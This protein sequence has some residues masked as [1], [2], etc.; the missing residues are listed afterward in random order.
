MRSK[1]L[2]LA[3][4]G[5][6]GTIAAVGASKL[7]QGQGSAEKQPMA[8]IFVTVQDVEIGEQ[9]TAENIKL[10]PWPLDRMPEGA[11]KDLENVE[12]M[13]SNQRLY[14]GEPLIARKIS[15]TPGNT[16]RDIPRDYS[17][18]SLQTDT[19]TGMGT[20]VEP[21]DRVNVI[22]FFKKSDVIP[23]TMTQKI[24]TGIRVYA[25]DGRKRRTEGETV[26][27]PARTISLLIH[28]KD[29][30]AWTYANELGRVRLSLSHPDEYEN[31]NE[32]DGADSSGQEFLKWIADHSKKADEQPVVVT[33]PEPAVV[34]V[35]AAP[36]DE[37]LRMQKISG[38]VTYMYELRDGIWVVVQSSDQQAT[39]TSEN[40][41]L[42]DSA[43]PV[44]NEDE[45]DEYGYL[46]GSE[47]PFFEDGPS[48]SQGQQQA[49]GNGRNFE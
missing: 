31:N 33:T 41:G 29:E 4:A 8:E 20:L 7:L 44:D 18:V 43:D 6:C 15:A 3:I 22:G 32:S 30:E 27:T 42:T 1:T 38:G 19:A 14:A 5:I 12:G 23:Q 13:Y 16:R 35:A 28:K 2:L 36:T 46:N 37:P 48:A 17:V 21:G 26:S 39:G 40:N 49:T 47:S 24:L 11:I 9:F 34:E 25:V 10:E 45:S